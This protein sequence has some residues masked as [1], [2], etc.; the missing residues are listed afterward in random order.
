MAAQSGGHRQWLVVNIVGDIGMAITGLL[1]TVFA[2]RN[3]TLTSC[4]KLV[5]Y[6]SE[7]RVGI[8]SSV[9]GYAGR[10]GLFLHQNMSL[11][12]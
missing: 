3:S 10:N 8:R 1:A 9:W 11:I 4:V 5:K 7:W 12:D 6:W 2:D